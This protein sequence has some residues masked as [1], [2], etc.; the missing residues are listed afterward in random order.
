MTAIPA[1]SGFG[2]EIALD[3]I[4]FDVNSD[5]TR[6]RGEGIGDI[7]GQAVM[8]GMEDSGGRAARPLPIV[9]FDV[10][11]AAWLAAYADLLGGVAATV[12]AYD[13]TEPITRI[14]AAR[15]AM[16]RLGPVEADPFFGGAHAAPMAST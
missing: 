1:T 16:E 7:L 14:L 5:A 10:A 15:D 8:G 9:R 11:D 4:W 12:R 13:P 2:L 3:D 6:S